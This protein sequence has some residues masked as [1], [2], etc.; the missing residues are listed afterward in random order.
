MIN[1]E[2]FVLLVTRKLAGAATSAE[3]AELDS[4][5]EQYPALKERYHHLH[6]YFED[7]LHLSAE[8]TEQALQRTLAKIK[9]PQTGIIVRADIIKRTGR[10]KWAAA[11]AAAMVLIGGAFLVSE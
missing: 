7:P 6:H 5:L 4:L 10:W 1:E 3:L 2:H 11:A 9:S 8:A